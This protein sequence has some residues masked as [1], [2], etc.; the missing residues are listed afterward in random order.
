MFCSKQAKIIKILK[1]NN[2]KLTTMLPSRKQNLQWW[3]YRYKY[4]LNYQNF[5]YIYIDA[6]FI[7]IGF[8]VRYLKIC[9]FGIEY[10]AY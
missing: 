2:K 5:L 1:L 7:L 8:N 3:L 4:T 6:S 10:V 9:N